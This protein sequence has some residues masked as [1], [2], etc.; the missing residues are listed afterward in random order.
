MSGSAEPGPG[1]VPQVGMTDGKV[2]SSLTRPDVVQAMGRAVDAVRGLS[3]SGIFFRVCRVGEGADGVR[4]L[5]AIGRAAAA[6]PCATVRRRPGRRN[7]DHDKEMK[8][9]LVNGSSAAM[10]L[11]ATNDAAIPGKTGK[12]AG[13]SFTVV[14][15][16]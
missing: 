2:L 4:G 12:T 9:Q 11:I 7:H 13:I 3:G 16:N 5:R 8:T 6:T 15:S 10:G 1:A 14:L